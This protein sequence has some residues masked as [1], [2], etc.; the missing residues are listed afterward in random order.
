MVA[1]TLFFCSALRGGRWSEAQEQE[2]RAGNNGVQGRTDR[3][4]GA[5]SCAPC[6]TAHGF[7]SEHLSACWLHKGFSA[8]QTSE[9]DD[10]SKALKVG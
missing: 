10:T 2:S 4:H 7:Q 5:G 8:L 9:A 1:S 3:S 6:G